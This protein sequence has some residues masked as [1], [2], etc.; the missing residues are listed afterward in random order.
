MNTA[1]EKSILLKFR[2]YNLRL[3]R[4]REDLGMSQHAAALAMGFNSQGVLLKYENMKTSPIAEHLLGE[5]WKE[6]AQRVADF[7]GYSCEYLWPDEVKAIRKSAFRLEL[8]SHEVATFLSPKQD[9]PAALQLSAIVE[10]LP[11]VESTIIV[12]HANGATLDEIGSR[13]DLSRERIR[14]E[15]TKAKVHVEKLVEMKDSERRQAFVATIERGRAIGLNS[16]Q[17]DDPRRLLLAFKSERF[18][19]QSIV[20]RFGC[21]PSI[22]KKLCSRSLA[23]GF[24]TQIEPGIYEVVHEQV[25]E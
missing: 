25:E 22:A 7:Y 10:S 3:V 11:A 23:K 24:I 14:Q 12:A 16:L 13:F 21:T 2:A 17:A 20:L 8:A 9:T 18:S 4:A 5:V 19:E 15:L 6:S 1:T